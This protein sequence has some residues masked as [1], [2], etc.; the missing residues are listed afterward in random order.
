MLN[1]RARFYV[2]NKIT[3]GI[4]IAVIIVAVLFLAFMIYFGERRW[5]ELEAR[6]NQEQGD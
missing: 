4:L 3:G 6:Q 2:S 1:I 5:R